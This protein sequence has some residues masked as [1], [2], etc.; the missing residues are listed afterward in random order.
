[1]AGQAENEAEEEM[2]MDGQKENE[3]EEM[4]FY[5]GGEV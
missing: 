4:E 3:N 5:A 2:S 1:M